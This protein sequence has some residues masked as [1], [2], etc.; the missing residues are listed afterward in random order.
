MKSY[1]VKQKKQTECI[2]PSGYKRAK[3]GKLM[4]FCKCAECGIMKFKFVKNNPDE[5]VGGSFDEA[6][7][8]TMGKLGR[9]GLSKAIKSD[10]SKKAASKMVGKM[11]DKIA[12]NIN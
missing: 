10:M 7:L 9:V 4:Y 11:L 1:C 12:S 2:E 6:I 8:E 5:A 3:N